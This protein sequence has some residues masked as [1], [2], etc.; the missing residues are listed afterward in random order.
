MSREAGGHREKISFTNTLPKPKRSQEKERRVKGIVTS[1]KENPLYH[2]G[3]INEQLKNIQCKFV[4]EQWII[5]SCKSAY[6]RYP[7]PDA[8]VSFLGVLHRPGP[9]IQSAHRGY[10]TGAFLVSVT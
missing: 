9:P 4:Q 8:N 7:D 2:Q 5:S 10:R 3:P 1:N 6:I